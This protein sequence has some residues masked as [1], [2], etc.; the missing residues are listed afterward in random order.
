[1][2]FLTTAFLLLVLCGCDIGDVSQ[3]DQCLRR[4]IF[5]QCLNQVPLGPSSALYNDWDKVI[6]QCE[7]AAYYQ[8]RR[9]KSMIKPECATY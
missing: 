3:E 6:G 2:K 1:M 9:K 8:S 7:S 4:E 5:T